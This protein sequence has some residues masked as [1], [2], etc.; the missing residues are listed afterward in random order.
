MIFAGIAAFGTGFS[1]TFF[2]LG[3]LLLFLTRLGTWEILH[4]AI[5]LTSISFFVGLALAAA[6]CSLLSRRN[7]KRGI[8]RCPYCARP[9]KGINI[10]CD[11]PEAQALKP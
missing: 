2:L 5:K 8:Y 4:I 11:C 10:L 7:F 3:F 9:L 1:V 6:T